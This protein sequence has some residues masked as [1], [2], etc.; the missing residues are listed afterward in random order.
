MSRSNPPSKIESIRHD[1]IAVGAF[2][3]AIRD[4]PKIVA[5]AKERP[6]ADDIKN[7]FEVYYGGR[8]P[9]AA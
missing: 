3:I 6:K 7:G 5:A 1:R 9:E 2:T 4:I 8:P